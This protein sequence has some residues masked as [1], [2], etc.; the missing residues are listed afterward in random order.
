MDPHEL[1]ADQQGNLEDEG[2]VDCFF[3]TFAEEVGPKTDAEVGSCETEPDAFSPDVGVGC[4]DTCY[5]K[6]DNDEEPD[7]EETVWRVDF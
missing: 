7:G 1:V 4:V 5:I 2:E 3:G 6:G